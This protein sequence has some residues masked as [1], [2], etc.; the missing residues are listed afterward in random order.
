[1]T[2]RA[3]ALAAGLLA[4]CAV[5][6]CAEPCCRYDEHPIA[7][8][9]A[10][11]GELLA[12]L[13]ID[14][15]GEGLAV[16]DTGFP[17]TVMDVPNPETPPRIRR[18][19]LRVRAAGPAGVMATRAV[20]RDVLVLETRLGAIGPEDAP[21]RPKLILGAGITSGFALELAFA[22][23]A[24]TLWARQPA[25]DA[26]LS[27]AGYAVLRAD[28]VGGGELEAREPP[29]R[30]GTR[31]PHQ[32]ARSR[33]VVRACGAPTAF[34]PELPLPD[35]CCRSDERRLSTGA[36]LALLLA[37]GVGPTVLGRSAFQ[38]VVA[39]TGMSFAPISDR[40][41]RLAST[42][43]SIPAVW[44]RLP[45]LALIDQEATAGDDP[46][47]CAELAR[48]R[49]LE[50]VAIRQ[51]RTPALAPCALPCDRDPRE[52]DRAR[53]SAA[54]V[55]LADGIEVAVIDDAEPF[56]QGLRADVRPEGPEIDGILGAAALAPT[57]L[58]L[59]FGNTPVR[60]IWSCD[61][62]AAPGRCRA[63]AR[64]PRLRARGQERRCYGLPA[65]GLP[66]MCENRA[67]TCD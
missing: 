6:G 29:D 34:D 23:P 17:V 16:V 35:R 63:V 52:P 65:H 48:S 61:P 20:L 5:A 46:G 9:R 50:Q 66:E 47:P 37:S 56:L 39:A 30:F 19:T 1:M 2:D 3:A 42:S 4:L 15:E 40:P 36:D 53:N 60:S 14:G 51:A 7:L 28:R 13:S 27:A 57:R 31:P 55:E 11:S 64:C 62:D 32:Y 22:T 10:A 43:R 8:A 44:H 18:R 12:S 38:R 58:E 67:S 26:F 41:L 24:M 33:I 45:R 21:V 25:A 54:Y 49:R 59:D